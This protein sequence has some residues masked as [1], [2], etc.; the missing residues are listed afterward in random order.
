MKILHSLFL[1]LGKQIVF[2]AKVDDDLPR[3]SVTLLD[4][5]SIDYT[6]GV[7]DLLFDLDLIT[8]SHAFLEPYLRNH[9]LDLVSQGGFF[10][11]SCLGS[12]AFHFAKQ[13]NLGTL[14]PPFR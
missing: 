9:F 4:E 3:N 13:S 7:C 12:A 6:S 11:G 5:L 2:V 14:W 1:Y 8:K 10:E